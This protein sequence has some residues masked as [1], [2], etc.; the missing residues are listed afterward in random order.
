[1]GVVGRAFNAAAAAAE[2]SEVGAGSRRMKADAAAVAAFGLAV[3][4]VRGWGRAMLANEC[5]RIDGRWSDGRRKDEAKV[6]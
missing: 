2:E 3:S 4:L 6:V 1:M 5:N